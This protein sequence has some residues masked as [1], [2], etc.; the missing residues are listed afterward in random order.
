MSYFMNIRFGSISGRVG[1]RDSSNAI[2]GARK[3][4]LLMTSLVT[5]TFLL[6]WGPYYAVAVHYWIYQDVKGLKVTI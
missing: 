2:R 4:A 5:L 3:K 1:R 6:F